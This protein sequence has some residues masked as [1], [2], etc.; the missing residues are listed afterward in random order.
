MAKLTHVIG[1][2]WEGLYL[3]GELIAQNHSLSARDVLDAIVMSSDFGLSRVGWDP[4]QED[5]YGQLPDHLED[6]KVKR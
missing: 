3:D 4:Q 5:D 1:N 6:V 2:D